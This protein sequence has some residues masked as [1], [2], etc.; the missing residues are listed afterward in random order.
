MWTHIVLLEEID[1]ALKPLHLR[2]DM[3]T[4]AVHC[5]TQS[6]ILSLR[7]LETLYRN[8]LCLTE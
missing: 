5:A 3:L 7:L 8:V 4:A 2:A 1:F 6:L